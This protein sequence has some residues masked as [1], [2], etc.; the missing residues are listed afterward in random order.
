MNI[1]LTEIEAFCIKENYQVRKYK[2]FLIVYYPFCCTIQMDR[3]MI[4]LHGHINFRTT[5]VET[6]TKKMK[7][8]EK[9]RGN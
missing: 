6:A 9:H 2:D 4:V 3:Q 1:M 8:Y 7:D 5:E